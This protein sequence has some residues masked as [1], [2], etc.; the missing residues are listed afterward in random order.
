[1][2]A[3]TFVMGWGSICLL[4]KILLYW[5]VACSLLFWLGNTIDF[6]HLIFKTFN[7][8]P[9]KIYQVWQIKSAD[10]GSICGRRFFFFYF[11][12]LNQKMMAYSYEFFIRINLVI[13]CT[14]VWDDDYWSRLNIQQ[15]TLAFVNWLVSYLLFKSVTKGLQFSDWDSEYNAPYSMT[16]RSRTQKN[17]YR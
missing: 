5:L 2:K 6:V 9:W 16:I 7:I 17:I 13:F 4:M 8:S 12:F 3:G 14:K 15:Q 10:E 1:M 11:E